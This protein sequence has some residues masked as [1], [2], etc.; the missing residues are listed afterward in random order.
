MSNGLGNPRYPAIKGIMAVKEKQSVV[1]KPAD[2]GIDPSQVGAAG[3]RTRLVK[4]FQM[5][6]EGK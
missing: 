5:K 2:I 6:E 1:W 4:L 3:R